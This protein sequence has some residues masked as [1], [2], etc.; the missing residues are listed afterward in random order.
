MSSIVLL[1]LLTSLLCSCTV[2]TPQDVIDEMTR[3]ESGVSN[4]KEQG[5]IDEENVSVTLRPVSE[6]TATAKKSQK[7][8]LPMKKP[9][10]RN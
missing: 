3:I 1:S 7:S 9:Y 10:R 2:E 4:E 5:V 8:R 6:V